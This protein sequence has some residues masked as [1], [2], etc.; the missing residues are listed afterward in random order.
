MN[1]LSLKPL[2]P[3]QVSIRQNTNLS[4]SVS[5]LAHEL[6]VEQQIYFQSLTE[7]C[8]NGNEDER[9]NVFRSLSSDAALQPLLPRLVRF[10][11]DG[12][13]MNIFLRDLL[14]VIRFLS[15]MKMLSINKHVAFEKSLALIFSC[16]LTCLSCV[17]DLPKVNGQISTT[18]KTSTTNYSTIW[19]LR[20]QTSDLLVD[21][22]DR[23]SKISDLTERIVSVL[24][25]NLISN[26]MTKTYS[27]VYASLRTLIKITKTDEILSICSLNRKF[28]VDFDLEPLEQQKMFDEKIVEFLKKFRQNSN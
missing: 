3:R 11:H 20:E 5:C 13:L 25:T 28:D 8:F 10:I 21:F 17:F 9:T 15:M 16:L 26:S 22:H 6:S 2:Y 23:Y 14:F 18:E 24:Q 19:I 1:N 12:I 7:T 27:I 4:T